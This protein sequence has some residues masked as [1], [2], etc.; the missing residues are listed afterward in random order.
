MRSKMPNCEA[1]LGLNDKMMAHSELFHNTSTPFS[2]LKVIY[3][4]YASLN[5]AADI[6]KAKGVIESIY[7]MFIY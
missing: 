3:F 7:C 5:A 4:D 2:E 1:K 6:Y